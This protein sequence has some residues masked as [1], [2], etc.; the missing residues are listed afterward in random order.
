MRRVGRH[1]AASCLIAV[2]LVGVDPISCRAAAAPPA[3]ST[4]ITDVRIEMSTLRRLAD[5]SDNFHLT[6]HSDGAFMAPTATAGASCAA[7]SPSG[8]SA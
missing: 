1:V 5:E 7:T 8:R 4:Y 3:P 6:W 2:A